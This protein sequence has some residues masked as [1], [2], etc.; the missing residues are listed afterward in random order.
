MGWRV[1]SR[2]DGGACVQV[3]VSRRKGSRCG[4]SECVEVAAVEDRAVLVRDSTVPG[5]VLAVSAEA[6]AAL[7]R[8]VRAAPDLDR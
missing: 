6:W 2:C 4:T 3:A 7:V 8:R 1:S 5:V